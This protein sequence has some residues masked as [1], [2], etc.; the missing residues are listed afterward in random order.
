MGMDELLKAISQE[1]KMVLGLREVKKDL[2]NIKLIIMSKDLTEEE[3]KSITSGNA[4]VLIYDGTP[5]QLG[6]AIG[7]PHPV[8]VIGLKSISERIEA[9]LKKV[10]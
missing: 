3:K 1:K 9:E 8:K 4:K 2:K 6:R 7:R 10:G 5:S